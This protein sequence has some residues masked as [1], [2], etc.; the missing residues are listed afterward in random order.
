[1]AGAFLAAVF[2]AAVLVA[3]V[4]VAGALLAGALAADLAMLGARPPSYI[5]LTIGSDIGTLLGW[6]YVLEGSRLG[7][8]V[9]LQTVIN[10]AEPEVRKAIAF[11]QH[12]D[13]E[14]FWKSFKVELGKINNEPAAIAK[15]CL[16][17]AAG[18]HCFVDFRV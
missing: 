12:G 10:S 14:Q 5:A 15:A 16:G 8:R 18:Y 17:A 13:G 2:L 7:A 4:L 3:A 1:M 11:L 9:I 6:S